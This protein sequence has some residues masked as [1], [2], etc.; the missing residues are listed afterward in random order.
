MALRILAFFVLA[1]SIFFMPFWVSIVLAL[2]GMVYFSVFFEAVILFFLSDL[3]F[4]V[5]EAKFFDMVFVSFFICLVLLIVIEIF[6]KKLKF[7]R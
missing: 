5:K 2:V 3:L 7:Y 4:G 1:F 6:K